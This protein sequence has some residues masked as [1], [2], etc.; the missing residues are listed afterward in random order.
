M[1]AL[2]ERNLIELVG[3]KVRTGNNQ[4]QK[5]NK[6]KKS[7]IGDAVLFKA[8]PY[9]APVPYRERGRLHGLNFDSGCVDQASRKECRPID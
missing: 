5:K 3:E 1:H 7:H 4:E 6:E 9:D 8:P 2:C